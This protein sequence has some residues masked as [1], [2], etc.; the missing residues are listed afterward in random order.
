LNIEVYD[1]TS[2]WHRRMLSALAFPY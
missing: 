2:G 1:V